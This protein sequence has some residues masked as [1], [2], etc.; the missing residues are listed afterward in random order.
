MHS[1]QLPWG[2]AYTYQVEAEGSLGLMSKAQSLGSNPSPTPVWLWLL[3]KT[4]GLSEPQFTLLRSGSPSS[5]PLYLPAWRVGPSKQDQASLSADE[6][7]EAQRGWKMP[8]GQGPNGPT[9]RM[10]MK[11]GAEGC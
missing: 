9:V 2:L 11:G 4:T 10:T 8:K 5:H 7:D 3:R 6:E 1:T